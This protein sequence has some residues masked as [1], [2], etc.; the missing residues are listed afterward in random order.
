MFTTVKE[1]ISSVDHIETTFYTGAD[2]WEA[3]DSAV[4]T[5]KGW[6]SERV[7]YCDD[8]IMADRTSIARWYDAMQKVPSWHLTTPRFSPEEQELGS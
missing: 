8:T 5:Q 4:L 3:Y 1:L 7:Y 2:D 6:A